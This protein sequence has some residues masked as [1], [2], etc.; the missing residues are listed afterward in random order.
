MCLAAALVGGERVELLLFIE[1]ISDLIEFVVVPKVGQIAGRS[2]DVMPVRV[3]T[4]EQA[5]NVIE[6]ALRLGFE[7]SG[8]DRLAFFVDAGGAGNEQ[9]GDVAEFNTESTREGYFRGVIVCFIE[10]G[11]V[12]NG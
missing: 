1:C 2:D 10:N 6:G 5:G 7:V 8:V 4:L 12:L 11:A 9:H 3:F